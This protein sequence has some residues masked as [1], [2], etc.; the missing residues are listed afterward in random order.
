[1]PK[2]EIAPW[3][4]HRCIGCGRCCTSGFE[5]WCPAADC[6]RLGKIDWAAR[7]PD[8]VSLPTPAGGVCAFPSFAG[9]ADVQAACERLIEDRG[10]LVVPGSCFGH[11]DRMRIGY[12]GPTDELVAGLDHVAEVVAAVR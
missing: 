6:E 4:R 12:G 5:V 2:Y 7:H 11:P 3:L 9:C 1:M 8:L 10:V